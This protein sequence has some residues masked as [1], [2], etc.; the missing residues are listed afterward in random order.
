M[1]GRI[2]DPPSRL[3]AEGIP[4]M[5]D[6]LPGKRAAGDYNEEL[7]PPHEKPV[8]ATEYGITAE[9]MNAGEPLDRRLSHEEPD[10]LDEIVPDPQDPDGSDRLTG[11][12][13]TPGAADGP[14]DSGTVEH[15]ADPMEEKA[16]H[17]EESP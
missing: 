10:T 2:P 15:G 9:E 17:V 13:R 8:A 7:E 12:R 4:D 14:A 1:A 11:P 5:D 16:I 3:E 6:S